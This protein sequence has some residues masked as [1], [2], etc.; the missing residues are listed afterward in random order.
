MRTLVR[1]K[2]TSQRGATQV[3]FAL[4]ILTV[5]IL[6]F[7]TFE[8]AM[9]VYTYSVLSDAA[10]EGVRYAIVHGSQNGSPSGPSDYS[11]V[12]SKVNSYAQLS[13]HD[14]SA[15]NV[16]PSYIDNDN[17]APHRVSVTVTY[18]YVPYIK[19]PFTSP[20]ITTSAQGRIVY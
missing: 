3:E 5:V 20:T 13:L 11:N 8:M 1:T 6:I 7:W 4:S 2:Q 10:K 12:V 16:S 18:T 15:I 9:V 17:D 19:L 14:I